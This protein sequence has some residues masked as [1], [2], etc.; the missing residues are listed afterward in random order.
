MLWPEYVQEYDGRKGDIDLL[1]KHAFVESSTGADS[2]KGY[3][4]QC[5]TDAEAASSL[6]HIPRLG[7]DHIE[8]RASQ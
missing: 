3:N 7:K 6:Y 2:G 1:S 8:G 5:M 4:A